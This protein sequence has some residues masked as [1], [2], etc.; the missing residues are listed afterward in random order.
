MSGTELGQCVDKSV[1]FKMGIDSKD[2]EYLASKVK[3][4]A[5]SQ[6]RSKCVAFKL[7]LPS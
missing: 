5:T 6:T 2:A 3:E 7:G 4:M 1:L